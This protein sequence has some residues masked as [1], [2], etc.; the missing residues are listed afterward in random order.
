MESM[1][2][3]VLIGRNAE[4]GTLTDA[5]AAA[6]EGRGAVVFVTGDAGVGKSRLATEAASL[7]RS[8]GLCVLHGRAVESSVPV[9]FRPISEALMGIA[10][11]GA[12][13]D[14]PGIAD[15]RAALGA[16]VPEWSRPGDAESEISPVIFGEALLRLLSAPGGQGCL[17]ALEDLQ[18]ADP[19][20]LA[21]VEYLADNVA[22]SHVLVL[23]TL[24]DTGQSACLDLLHSLAARRVADRIEV[25]RLGRRAVAEMAAACL[26]SLDV[27]R[28]VGRLLADCDG[29][30]FAV[31]EILAAAVS[32]GEL[33]HGQFGWQV[34]DGVVTGVPA[35]IVGSVRHRLAALGPRAVNVIVSAAVLGRQFDWRLLSDVAQVSETEVL[36]ALHRA[37]NVQLIEPITA[38]GDTFRFRHSLTRDAIVSDLLSPERAARS[39]RAATAI[40]RAHPG[41]PGNWCELV[42]E[43]RAEAGQPLEAARLLLT[44]GCR[45]TSQGALT[46]A[47]DGLHDAQKLLANA[48]DHDTM[49]DIEIDEALAEA[50]ALSGDYEQ[51]TLLADD[52]IAR[53][54]AAGADPRRQALIRIMAASTRPEDNQAAAAAHLDEARAIANQLHDA[55]LASRVD[56]VAARYALVSGDLNRAEELASRSLAAAESAGLT[57]WAVEVALQSLDVIGRRERTR[58][59]GMARAAFE[60]AHQIAREQAL[61]VWRIRMLHELATLDLLADRSTGRLREVRELAQQAG[62]ISIATVIDLQLA[63]VWSLGDDL[64]LTLAAAR[65]C[66]RGAT[67]VSAHRIEAMALC[68]QALV[69]AIRS[70][71]QAAEQATGRAELIMPSDP[72][73]MLHSRGQ[74][75]VVASL[76]RDDVSRAVQDSSEA[77]SR[78]GPRTLYGPQ[79]GRG[80]YSAA[81]APLVARGRS[82]ALAALLQAACDGDAAGAIERAEAAGAC[83]GWNRG[84]LAYAEAVLAGQAGDCDRATA[85]A[86]EGSA[87]F[88]P[89]APWW[90]HLAQRLVATAALRDGWGQ[91]VGWMRDAAA[92]FEA[93][94]HDR[95]AAAC[96]GILRKAGERVPRSGRGVAQVP[97]QMRRLGVTSREMDVFLLV[98][99]GFSNSEIAERL[100]I[101][102][103]TVETHVASLVA[104]TGQSGRR[105][106]VAHAAR[107]AQS[108]LFAGHRAVSRDPCRSACLTQARSRPRSGW[109]RCADRPDQGSLLV[110]STLTGYT[111]AT[112]SPGQ[113]CR[114]DRPYRHSGSLESLVPGLR[115]TRDGQR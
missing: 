111:W 104:K 16:L 115:R 36:Q 91:P 11:A 57:G 34:N 83:V 102:P 74:I 112:G 80:F 90:N 23:V 41:L 12:V 39:E 32:S 40:E 70:D 89:F 92:G 71:G 54:A 113:S 76:F 5:L 72:E 56:A 50:L 103:K 67:Q 77:M 30:P 38:D 100:F 107:F 1:L 84:C 109:A 108:L 20:T 87:C 28:G 19:E 49:L 73:V 10:R 45:A 6:G 78:Y 66:E 15:Y 3:P 69:F 61:G 62:I 13:P 25:P 27:P 99:Q 22:S 33:V 86:A 17:L 42:A 63:N 37:H 9:P 60:R 8:H 98:A 114:L 4:V 43:L 52:L 48:A 75:A 85:L 51:L 47:I 26:D 55:E 96:R 65:Q 110:G 88:A 35:S 93:S 24:R 31:E 18:W 29:L 7:A 106:L 64:D 105:E 82:W 68:L 81:Q 53:L 2:C 97:P 14:S 46:S 44:A 94:G 59:F 79:R 21:I 95:L 101:S 58:D